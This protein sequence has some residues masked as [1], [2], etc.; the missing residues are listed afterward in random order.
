MIGNSAYTMRGALWQNHNGWFYSEN[1]FK[2]GTGSFWMLSKC[3]VQ[4]GD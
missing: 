2:G 1:Q 4:E 3:H